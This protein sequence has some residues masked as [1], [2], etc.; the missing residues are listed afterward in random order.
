VVRAKAD[1]D[2]KSAEAVY[3]AGKVSPEA[4][5]RA[6]TDAGYPATLRRP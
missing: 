6:V 1:L 2:T 5:A 3:D 4:L